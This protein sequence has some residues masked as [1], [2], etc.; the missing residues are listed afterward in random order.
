MGPGETGSFSAS[1][2]RYD[3]SWSKFK[4][5][6]D[7]KKGNKFFDHGLFFVD[8]GIKSVLI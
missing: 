3:Y 2:L 4:D 7:G 8:C 1:I 5:R 6:G